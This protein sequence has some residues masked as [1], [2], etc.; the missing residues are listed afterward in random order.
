MA[1]FVR[2][3]VGQLNGSA[4]GLICRFE[5]LSRNL[6]LPR[7]ASTG[8]VAVLENFTLRD[9]GGTNPPRDQRYRSIFC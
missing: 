4:N 2:F 1:A 6:P 8:E 9:K 5:F 7:H 3:E